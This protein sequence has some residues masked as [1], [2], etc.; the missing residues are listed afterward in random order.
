MVWSTDEPRPFD[1][2]KG[3][4]YVVVNDVEQ[5]RMRPRVA[6]VSSGWRGGHQRDRPT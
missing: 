3:S 5:R 4:S 6:S 2:D 1:H